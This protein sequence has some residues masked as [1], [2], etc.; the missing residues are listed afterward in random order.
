MSKLTEDF[1]VQMMKDNLF[2]GANGRKLTDMKITRKFRGDKIL[3]ECYAK[4]DGEYYGV[5]C[6]LPNYTK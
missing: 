5:G 3:L 2:L 6:K 4:I 1:F